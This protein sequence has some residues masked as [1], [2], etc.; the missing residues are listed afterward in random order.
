MTPTQLV[1]CFVFTSISLLI[2][3]KRYAVD[4]APTE[5]IEGNVFRSLSSMKGISFLT[6]K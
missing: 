1:L 5:G 6:K 4:K 3:V 2:I